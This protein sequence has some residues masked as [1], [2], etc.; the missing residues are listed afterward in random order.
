MSNGKD[1]PD[2]ED[3][4]SSIRKCLE[5]QYGSSFP[6]DQVYDYVTGKTTQR[7]NKI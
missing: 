7:T 1:E 6:T 5:I 2:E 3:Y 4:K